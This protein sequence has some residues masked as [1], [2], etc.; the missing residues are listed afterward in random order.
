MK[1]I[2]TAD[3]K[4]MQVGDHQY[5]NTGGN[6]MVSTFTVWMPTE[7]RTLWVHCSDEGATLATCDYINQEV[8]FSDEMIIADVMFAMLEPTTSEYFEL[9]RYCHFEYLKKDC[10]HYGYVAATWYPLL[11]DAHKQLLPLGYIAWH[12]EEIGEQFATDGENIIMDDSYK[13]SEPDAKA[14]AELL[15]HIRTEYSRWS[16]CDDESLTEEWYGVKVSIAFGEKSITV[17]N[18]AAIYNALERCLQDYISEQ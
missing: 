16:D 11:T 2:K 5:T 8:E 10:K 14:A 4:E 12:L 1:L 6:C 7:N 13:V 3:G 18:C 9:F 15:Q 17:S